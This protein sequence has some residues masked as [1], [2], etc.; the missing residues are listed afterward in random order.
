MP[1]KSGEAWTLGCKQGSLKF[2]TTVERAGQQCGNQKTHELG[3]KSMDETGG[4]R[5]PGI[6]EGR[7]A[8]YLQGRALAV[9]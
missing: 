3:L 7:L 8:S 1:G 2:L 5:P 9:S 6:Q 4:F